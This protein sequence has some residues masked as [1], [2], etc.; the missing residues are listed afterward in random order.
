DLH[1]LRLGS[2]RVDAHLEDGRRKVFELVRRHTQ[3]RL[4]PTQRGTCR[5]GGK[6]RGCRELRGDLSELVN[7]VSG[8]TQL[9]TEGGDV[10][11]VRERFGDFGRKVNQ[12]FAQ[13]SDRLAHNPRSTLD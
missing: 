12:V 1:D 11:D 10:C 8:D 5:V 4:E 3:Q 2:N 6:V 9:S 13:L 7:A